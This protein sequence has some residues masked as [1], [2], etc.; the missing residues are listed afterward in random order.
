M[1]R[2]QPVSESTICFTKPAVK[3]LD[4]SS[5]QEVSI[6]YQV[7]CP[8]DTKISKDIPFEIKLKLDRAGSKLQF[9]VLASNEGR[10]QTGVS[11]SFISRDSG[12]RR[13]YEIRISSSV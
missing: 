7:V 9:C 6:P 13:G 2:V 4:S 8:E 12:K 10:I 5:Q 3:L 11:I 1:I